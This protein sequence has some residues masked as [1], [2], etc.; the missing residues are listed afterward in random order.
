VSNRNP[1]HSTLGA[2]GNSHG[3]NLTTLRLQLLRNGYRPVP[4]TAPTYQHEKVQSPGKQPFF[5]DW[6]SICASATERTVAAWSAT[7]HN[8]PNTG[9][10][11]DWTPGVDID[12]PIPELAQTITKTVRAML[13]DTPLERTGMAPKTLLCYRTDAP[14][15]K[16]KTPELFFADGSK[17]QVEVLAKGQQFVAFGIHP[18]TGRAYEWLQDGPDIVPWADLPVATEAQFRAVVAACEAILRAA[19][20]RT[21]AELDGKAT[22]LAAASE[23]RTPGATVIDFAKTAGNN[24]FFKEVNRLALGAIGTWFPQIFPNAEFQPGTDAWRVRSKDLGRPLE[25][26]LS[27]H[28]TE[29]GRDF[30]TETSISPIDVVIE[31]GGAA[32]AVQAALWLCDQLQ[33]DPAAL[34]WKEKLGQE[35]KK[36]ADNG[37][38]ADGKNTALKWSEPLPLVPPAE[39]PQ[40]YPTDA[41]PPILRDACRA[42]Q[43]FGQQPMALVACS[44][45]AAAA[46]ATQGLANVA[47][48]PGLVGPISLNVLVVAQSG[49]RKTSADKRMSKPIRKWELEKKDA[50]TPEIDAARA[51]I[52]A[53]QAEKDGLLAKIKAGAGRPSGKSEK[54][55]VE[56]ADQAKLKY[57]LE[58]LEKRTPV[59]PIVPELFYEDV[60]P[61]KMAEDL[62]LGW[63]SASLWSDEAGLV[64]GG[65]GMGRDSLLRYLAMINR[66]WDGQPFS[67]KRSTTKSVTVQGRRLTTCLMMQEPVLKQLLAAGDG[68]SR[69][70]G[71]MARFLITWPVSTMGSRFYRPGDPDDPAL[72][73]YDVRLCALLDE[74]LP[75]DGEGMV[76][77]PPVLPLSAD[78]HALWVEFH[79]DVEREL[80]HQGEFEDVKDFAAKTADNAA[81]IAGVFHVLQYGPAGEIAIE[82]MKEAARLALWHLYEA[83]RIMGAIKVPKAVAEAKALLDWLLAQ[84]DDVAPKEILHRGPK[85]LRDRARRDEAIERLAKT[86]H[87]IRKK[88]G[89][90]EVLEINPKLRSQP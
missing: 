5:K 33:I 66:F 78:A 25:E 55:K 26:D 87:L 56:T 34:G 58:E 14:F 54:A 41:L 39:E 2:S 15:R 88:V 13:G 53:L 62:A 65:H 45:L 83:K 72:V 43:A 3:V 7:V 12:V 27:M 46:L 32:G 30:G 70:S 68:V 29:G 60:T 77:V 11:C 6:R 42:Y 19:G 9:L 10:L 48:A 4:I 63:P 31:H 24:T 1:R 64:V 81:R 51:A 8:H 76:L 16:I 82:T 37:A 67:R 75:V 80:A 28:P 86:H 18:G 40:P 23:A 57:D 73:A 47:R 22:K 74:P 52:A 50:M 90:K 84:N 89:S 44:A 20:G 36:R 59:A 21:K 85:R 38:A 71:F 61:E 17:A 79:N 69:G 49:E 35:R